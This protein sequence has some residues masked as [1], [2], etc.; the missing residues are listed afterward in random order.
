MKREAF[1]RAWR[2][3]GRRSPCSLSLALLVS[4]A[5]GI[6]APWAAAPDAAAAASGTRPGRTSLRYDSGSGD[7]PDHWTHAVIGSSR[8]RAR[9]LSAS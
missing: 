6:A 2:L 3:F 7:S 4:V 9:L 5:G 1:F 8:L